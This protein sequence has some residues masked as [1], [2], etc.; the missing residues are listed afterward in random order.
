M[1][2]LVGKIQFVLIS[3]GNGLHN[4]GIHMVDTARMLFGEI[5]AVQR[6]KCIDQFQEGP[7][8][9]DLNFSFALKTEEGVGIFFTPIQFSSYRENGMS[10]WGTEGRLDILNEGLTI[11]HYSRLPNRAMHGEYEVAADSPVLMES[12][13]GTAFYELYQNLIDAL[14]GQRL[15]CSPGESELLTARV[16]DSIVHT[17]LSGEEC[18]I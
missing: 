6:I 14:N 10:I 2:K 9:T 11:A 4:N 17:P 7:T 18:L 8:P 16:I 13:V 12:S 15:L 5:G 3:Y 1:N